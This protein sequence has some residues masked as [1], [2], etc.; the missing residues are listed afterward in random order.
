M[1]PLNPGPYQISQP[2][3]NFLTMGDQIV[4]D[5]LT[6]VPPS[7]NPGEQEWHLDI[8]F[9]DS[10]TL[11]NLKSGRYV[12]VRGEPKEGSEI[13]VNP[14]PFQLKLEATEQRN[15]CFIYVESN[16]QR[17]Y[18]NPSPVKLESRRCVLTPRP[19]EPW[20]FAFME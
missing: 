18:I 15:S 19:E 4:G 9:G 5:P 11:K 20:Q 1:I 14:G 7:D 17:L 16:D 10:V 12:G 2:N 8:R 3:Q 6:L 13:V